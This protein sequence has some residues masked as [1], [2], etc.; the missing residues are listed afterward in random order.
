VE[1][2]RSSCVALKYRP[3]TDCFPAN[4]RGEL[5]ATI[6]QG[7]K[8]MAQ[9]VVRS[10]VGQINGQASVKEL[11]IDGFVIDKSNVAQFS[12]APRLTH[13]PG[14]VGIIESCRIDAKKMLLCFFPP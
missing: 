14:L 7:N 4:A 1:H 3:F 6:K 8:Q 9:V 5:P 10:L 2:A 12:L 11:L 13:R